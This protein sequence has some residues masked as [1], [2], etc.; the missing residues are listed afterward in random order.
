M[1]R[2]CYLGQMNPTDINRTQPFLAH[3]ISG[4]DFEIHPELFKI[5]PSKS[6][7]IALDKN[8]Y[9]LVKLKLPVSNFDN[10]KVL[11]LFIF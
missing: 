10:F 3:L 5:L 6:N 9:Y 7:H 8:S 1:G 2:V 4:H 11:Y